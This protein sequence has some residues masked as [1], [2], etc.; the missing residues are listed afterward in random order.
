MRNHSQD[1]LPM[2]EAGT[3]CSSSAALHVIGMEGV[4]QAM[5]TEL[6]RVFLAHYSDHHNP[7]VQPLGP[8]TT[9]KPRTI[10]SH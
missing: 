9:L 2:E 6:R 8:H 7:C 4:Q 10:N 3:Y 1:S 5:S